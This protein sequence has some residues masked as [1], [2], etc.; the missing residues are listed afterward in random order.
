MRYPTGLLLIVVVSLSPTANAQV[1]EA[2]DS[3]FV[4]Q[5]SVTLDADEATAWTAFVR[6]ADWW[7][8]DHTYT[9]DAGNLSLDPTPGGCMCE[10]LP[11]GGFVEHMAVV[12][13]DPEAMLRMSGGLGPLQEHAVSGAMTW[14][15]TPEGDSTRLDL[16]YRVNGFVPGGLEG[17]AAPV[18][19]VLAQQLTRLQELLASS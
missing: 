8:P 12:Y 1:Q 5:R 17:W 7:H 18:D 14:T 2:S 13:A 19:G 11:S 9:M 16:V 3:H 15:F 4:I 6:V 10:A